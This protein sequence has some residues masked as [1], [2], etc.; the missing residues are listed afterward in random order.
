MRPSPYLVALE[1]Q[2]KRVDLCVF[3]DCLVSDSLLLAA[4][5]GPSRIGICVDLGIKINLS[6]FYLHLGL[7]EGRR[8]R[9]MGF[10]S[11]FAVEGVG[12]RAM[13]SG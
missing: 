9:V 13:R 11:A 1:T 5:E 2:G 10:D 12:A 7:T 6:H 3:S 8:G 4:L